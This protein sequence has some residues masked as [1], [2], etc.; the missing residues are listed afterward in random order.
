[1][2]RVATTLFDAPNGFSLVGDHS[3]HALVIVRGNGSS[4]MRATLERGDILMRL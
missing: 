1:M 3:E 4:Q 2:P